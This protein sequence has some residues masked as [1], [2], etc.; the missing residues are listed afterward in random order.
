M[1]KKK[2]LDCEIVMIVDR[3][4][5]MGSLTDSTISNFNEFLEKQKADPG[6]A[7]GTLV[8]F[9]HEVATIVDNVDLQNILPLDKKTYYANGLTALFDAVGS[10]VERI[11]K[12]HKK[13]GRPDKT[14]VC[15][16]TDGEENFSSEFDK[17]MVSK[18]VTKCQEKLNWDFF[19][20]G[21]NIDTFAEA[22][23][24]G[25]GTTA[26]MSYTASVGGVANAYLAIDNAV[27]VSRSSTSR[28][29]LSEGWKTTG[30]G[31]DDNG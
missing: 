16:I 8:L 6:T 7:R 21:A 30:D 15:I 14:I 17:E 31:N 11:R 9:N 12:R 28:T 25:I 26:A 13:G 27:K 29:N 5:S 10:T 24:L 18:L 22:G 2:V 1:L 3:S 4:G 19:F 20:L 23:S